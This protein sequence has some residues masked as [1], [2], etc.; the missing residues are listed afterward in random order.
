MATPQ[1]M[2]PCHFHTAWVLR[3]LGRMRAMGQ[4]SWHHS[5]DNRAAIRDGGAADSFT[6][7]FVSLLA[8][9]AL[10]LVL[11]GVGLASVLTRLAQNLVLTAQGFKRIRRRAFISFV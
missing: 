4:P 7:K 11:I 8:M 6:S 10:A 1:L 5:D 9:A 3:V 2:L